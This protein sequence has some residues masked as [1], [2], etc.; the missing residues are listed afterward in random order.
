MLWEFAVPLAQRREEAH[1]DIQTSLRYYF[2]TTPHEAPLDPLSPTRDPW[3]RREVPLAPLGRPVAP[4]FPFWGDP[5][6]DQKINDFSTPSEITQRAQKIYPMAP[7]GRCFMDFEVMLVS[8]FNVCCDLSKMSK[9]TKS[10]CGCSHSSILRIQ[11][12]QN[13]SFFNEFSI[14]FSCFFW[15]RSWNDFLAI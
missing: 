14:K 10:R 7:K 9:T 6:A 5:A 12:L 13:H 15:N 8:I 4:F 2:K 3:R 11:H 1:V